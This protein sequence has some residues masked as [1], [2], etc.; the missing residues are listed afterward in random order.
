MKQ[1]DLPLPKLSA[2]HQGG[3]IAQARDHM[4]CQIRSRFRQN[5]CGNGDL[6]GNRQAIKWRINLK[7]LQ[8]FRRAPRHSPTDRAPTRPQLHR[9][10][11]ITRLRLKLC[12]CQTR[13]RKAQQGAPLRHP[14]GQ[15]LF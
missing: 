13:P 14:I 8:S 7:A 4:G 1:N 10:K 11:R 15:G 3:A 12:R 9:Q 5:L 2:G 6:I